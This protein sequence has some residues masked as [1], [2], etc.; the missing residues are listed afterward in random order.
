MEYLKIT[1]GDSLQYMAD[2]YGHGLKYERP[3]FTFHSQEWESLAR[4]RMSIESMGYVC[5]NASTGE[6]CDK[7]VQ[8]F[9]KWSIVPRR[10]VKTSGYPSVEA[11]VLGKTLR[12]PIAI[13]PVGVQTIFNPDGELAAAK[14]AAREHVPY[15]YSTAAATP[16]E[17]VARANGDGERWFQLYWPANEHNDITVS[18][19]KR[20]KKHGFSAL[21]VTLDTYKLGWRPS[22][23][24]NGYN[25]FL[26]SD[27]VGTALGFTDPV[28]R[29]SFKAKHGKEIEQDLE[30]AASEWTGT[31]FPGFSHGWDGL[32]FLREHWDGPIILKGIQSVSDAR[33]C[34]ELGIDGIV[35]SNHGGRQQDGGPASLDCLVKIVDA[36]GDKL[37]IFFDSGVRC[38]AD[39]AKALALGA[40]MVL[41]GRPYVYGLVLGGEEGVGHVLRSLLGD[42]TMTLHLGG[43]PSASK[44]HLNRSCLEHED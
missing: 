29:R 14:A 17:E 41:I 5:G 2:V 40:Q 36:V 11:K 25:P 23:L 39:I 31:V 10:L 20:A 18:L 3:P 35:V 42:L 9:R 28:F 4:K 8:A 13:A 37:E 33:Q 6:T 1:A 44:E 43:L 26:R 15:I 27:T 30:T 12:T 19:L 38:G 32:E 16:I 24:D 7:N 21:F 34:V 22:D